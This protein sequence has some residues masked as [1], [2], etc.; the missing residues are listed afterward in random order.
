[1]ADKQVVGT[2]D[3]CAVT[4]GAGD[5]KHEALVD[6]DLVML[7][8]PA[9]TLVILCRACVRKLL[10]LPA[11]A[12]LRA[13]SLVI[14]ALLA[15]C[16]GDVFQAGALE[17]LE[18]GSPEL[19][20]GG[21]D[22]GDVDAGDARGRIEDA[23]RETDAPGAT[24]AGAGAVDAQEAGPGPETGPPDAAWTDAP[25]T[26]TGNVPHDDGFGQGFTDCSPAGV[27]DEQLAVDA[28]AAWCLNEGG[29]SCSVGCQGV[30][31][32]SPGGVVAQLSGDVFEWWFAGPKIGQVGH[33][34]GGCPST[35]AG[36]FQ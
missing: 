15:G 31:S 11:G 13:I 30:P 6:G 1:M 28:C 33:G 32:G 18:A 25:A 20:A 7:R 19:E 24:D 9:G 27:I 29:C 10:E 35:G 34:H 14:A 4:S 21:V 5:G 17:L 8:C 2:C 3:V 16:G 12:M 23:R 22:A 26:C 36:A